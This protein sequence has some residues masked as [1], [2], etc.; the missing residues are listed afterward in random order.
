MKIWSCVLRNMPSKHH[1]CRLHTLVSW[2][3]L[4]KKTLKGISYATAYL[5]LGYSTEQKNAYGSKF[6]LQRL[7]MGSPDDAAPWPT[8]YRYLNYELSMKTQFYRVRILD[9]SSLGYSFNWCLLNLAME[10][11]LCWKN[12]ENCSNYLEHSRLYKHITSNTK[13]IVL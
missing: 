12:G 7:G 9:Y 6:P 2:V 8:N 11:A 10:S 13:S 1:T 3:R 5:Y 4:H